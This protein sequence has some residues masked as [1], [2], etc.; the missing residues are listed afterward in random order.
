MGWICH[1]FAC[2]W[3]S[4]RNEFW[5]DSLGDKMSIPI[6]DTWICLP[7]KKQGWLWP[8]LFRIIVF[9][10]QSFSYF[11]VFCLFLGWFNKQGVDFISASHRWN[12]YSSG[13]RHSQSRHLCVEN[14]Y[15]AAQWWFWQCEFISMNECLNCLVKGLNLCITA[16]LLRL[17]KTPRFSSIIFLW[18]YHHVKKSWEFSLKVLKFDSIKRS[19]NVH[20]ACVRTEKRLSSVIMSKRLDIEFATW[21]RFYFDI[22]LPFRK[23]VISFWHITMIRKWCFLQE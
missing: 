7:E 9:Y 13:K 5:A 14:Y 16:G 11:Y 4:Q 2:S 6:C 19:G 12:K 17:L 1:W 21:N 20:K 18:K 22:F 8:M 23:D 10:W 3:F 15:K